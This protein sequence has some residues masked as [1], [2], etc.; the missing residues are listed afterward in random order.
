MVNVYSIKG[1]ILGSIE[2]PGVFKT[3]YRPDL[4]Q[5]AVVAEQANRRQIYGTYE[6]AGMQTSA[7]Y[8]GNRRETF[9][10][11]INRGQSRLPREKPGGGGLGKVRRVP[12]SVKGRPAHPPK[13]KDWHKK[14][15]NKEFLFAIKSAIAATANPNIV[16]KR[17][18]KIENIKE[19]PLIIENSFEKLSKTR[20]IIKTLQILG[21]DGDIERAGKK[22]I[23]SGRGKTRGYRQ[24]NRKGVL[25]VIN[26]DNGIKKGAKNIPYIDIARVD[27][28]SPELLA[29]GTHPGRLTLWTNSA[30]E[31]ID[32]I[33]DISNRYNKL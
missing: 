33:S 28:L 8:F 25:I 15:N 29:P 32:K 4:I 14:I 16:T 31:N 18:H 24:K 9:R 17:G 20:D 26:E 23:G 2:L 10:I 5:R 1:E 6:L 19:I 12:Q 27:E 22:R 11:T 30:I 21:L 7:D 3:D 13:K